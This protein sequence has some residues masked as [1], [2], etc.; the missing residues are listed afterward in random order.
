MPAPASGPCNCLVAESGVSPRTRSGQLTCSA[1]RSNSASTSSL[2]IFAFQ[3]L[4]TSPCLIHTSSKWACLMHSRIGW[5]CSSV[6]TFMPL[7]E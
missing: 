3:Y 7:R 6:R 5:P 1:T 4:A 2:L